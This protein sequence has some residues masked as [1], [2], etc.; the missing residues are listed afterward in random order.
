MQRY[1]VVVAG[2]SGKRMGSDIPKQFL[3]INGKPLLM[4]TIERIKDYDDSINIILVLPESQFEYWALLCKEYGFR[5]PF[6]LV[7]GGQERFF[8]VKNALEYVPND[9]VVGIHDG[10]RPFVSNQTLD[11]LFDALQNSDAVIPAIPPH[12]SVRVDDGTKNTMLNRNT[13]KLV[14]TP[15]CFKSNLIKDAY[16]TEYKSFFTDDASVVEYALRVPI[17]IVEGNRENIKI[18]TPLD[19]MMGELIYENNQ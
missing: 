17:T 7:C 1:M 4:R 18:T 2:G 14:Q 3:P 13:V 9:S 10:V 19:L 15:Q 12:E 8:S 16:T 6:K 5:I 11:R